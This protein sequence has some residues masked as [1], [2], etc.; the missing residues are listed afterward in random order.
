VYWNPQLLSDTCSFRL[1][2]TPGTYL[3]VVEGVTSDGR[4]VHEEIPFDVSQ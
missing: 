1:G 3:V 2:D 4:L